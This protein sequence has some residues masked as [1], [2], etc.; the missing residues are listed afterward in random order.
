MPQAAQAAHHAAVSPASP[1]VA[2][3]RPP[4]N[5]MI[6]TAR[7][8]SGGNAAPKILSGLTT[9]VQAPAANPAGSSKMI[10]GMRKLAAMIWQATASPTISASP[11]KICEA[12]IGPVTTAAL[13]SPAGIPRAK[14]HTRIRPR[15]SAVPSPS[16]S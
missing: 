16:P 14:A 8:T 10:A 3:S 11:A 9:V 7:L 2:R 4:S 5:K 1:L 15:C 12:L 13:I 6:A